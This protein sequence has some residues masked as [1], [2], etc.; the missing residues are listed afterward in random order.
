MQRAIAWLRQP[1]ENEPP[2]GTIRILYLSGH[3]TDANRRFYFLTSDTDIGDIEAT[4][5][6]DSDI[7]GWMRN[8]PGKKVIF[9]DACR[10]ASGLDLPAGLA[11]PD[12]NKLSNDVRS[13]DE[14]AVVYA[15]SRRSELSYEGQE[16][17]HGAFTKVLLDGLRGDAD[18]FQT[19]E[20]QTS[21]LGLLLE[22][23]V[24][25]LTE[26][27]QTPIWF[28]SQLSPSFTLARDR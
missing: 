7:T 24:K 25:Q 20:I 12:Y 22:V 23:K 11:F 5:I 9:L 13:E 1:A 21:G 4:A 6:S 15:S 2:A 27:K 10:S 17:K 19:G 14:G 26:G 18:L 16:W 28:P 3:G 8:V